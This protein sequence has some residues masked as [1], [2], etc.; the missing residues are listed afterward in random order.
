MTETLDS[1]GAKL[2][3]FSKLTETTF[4]QNASE[5]R[6]LFDKLSAV[7]VRLRGNGS[8]GLIHDVEDLKEWRKMS[9]RVVWLLATTTVA[10]IAQIVYEVITT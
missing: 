10:L 9:T 2:D 8:P 4:M 6:R 3:T 1:L 7:D 5:H